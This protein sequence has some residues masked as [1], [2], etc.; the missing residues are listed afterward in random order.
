MTLVRGKVKTL[1]YGGKGIMKNPGQPVV[2][3]PFT[4]P[5]DEIECQITQV[6]KNYSEAILKKILS[7]SSDRIVPLCPYFGTCGGCQLQHLSYEAQLH[8]K[9]SIV[10]EF[11]K[12]IDASIEVAISPAQPIWEYRRHI[13][14][15]IKQGRLG[16]YALDN[17]TLIEV[18]MCPIFT[19]RGDPIFD[20]IRSL[21][22]SCNEGKVK[23]LKTASHKY[24]L[25]FHFKQIPHAFWE[26]AQD[27]FFD[28][29]I[30]ITANGQKKGVVETSISVDGFKFVVDASTFLQVHADQSEQI[31]KAIKQY[32]KQC[33]AG[34][35][36]DLYCGIG[37]SSVLVAP[38]AK[39]II[40]VEIHRRAI[41]MAKSH[42]IPHINF[43]SKP[44]EEAALELVNQ[45]P[46]AAI[47]NPPR[48]GL[49]RTVAVKLSESTLERIVY[50]SCQPATLTRD[51]QI[52]KEKGFKLKKAQA[53][54]MFPQTGHVE[55]LVILER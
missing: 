2:F 8:Y 11:L 31:Y 18:E 7:P 38:Y 15:T 1:S 26:V 20:R 50:V 33:P 23:I 32:F 6:K 34:L 54:D 46:D 25:G 24:I 21:T 37:I 48:E 36:L 29:I 39:Q 49:N 5:E 40:A 17:Q 53:F 30:G 3:I 27:I 45:K 35:L 13:T 42:K 14:L 55:T 19:Q 43:Q 47:V 51:L 16:Y 12:K 10:Q 44:V 52:F 9:Q 4:C 28:P 41:E 22:S